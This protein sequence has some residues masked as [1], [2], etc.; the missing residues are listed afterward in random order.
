MLLIFAW[1]YF[2]AMGAS[3]ISGLFLIFAGITTTIK[4]VEKLGKIN[5]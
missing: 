2:I 3:I 1:V 4:A 5:K